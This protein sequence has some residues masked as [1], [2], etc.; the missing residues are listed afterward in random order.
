MESAMVRKLDFLISV[1]VLGASLGCHRHA[2]QEEDINRPPVDNTTRVD[3]PPVRDTTRVVRVVDPAI[4]A[5]FKDTAPSNAFA[6]E[7]RTYNVQKAAD[8]QALQTAVRRQR[9]L[10]QAA[11]PSSY[12]FLMRA[13]CFCPGPHGWLLLEVRPG[14]P[15]RAWDRSGKRVSPNDWAVFT[16]DQLYDGLSQTNNQMS[17]VQ[18]A[19]EER[20]HYPRY[21]RTSMIYPDGWSITQ[22]RALRPI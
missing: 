21:L 9:A 8:R 22:I 16:I 7:G 20:L 14:Q 6:T 15:L 17:Q 19:F 3:R 12:Q 13:D 4:A 10:W 11:K 1:M 18:I 2:V 5:L